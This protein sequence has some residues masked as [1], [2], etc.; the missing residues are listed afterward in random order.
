[1]S[2]KDS[3]PARHTIL[4]VDDHSL[5]S[6]GLCLLLNAEPDLKVIG[7]AADL[8]AALR[9]TERLQPEIILLDI[10]LPQGNS[11]DFLPRFRQGAPT[12]KILMLTMHEDSG[13][14]QKALDQGAVGY[15]LKRALDQDLLYAIRSV[16]RGE[17]YVQPAML[18]HLMASGT[19]P[20]TEP[21][22]P[23]PADDPEKL[24][25]SSLSEREREVITGVALG[26]TSKELGEKYFISEKTIATYRSR[27]MTK[28][29]LT[30]K[31]E[32]VELVL[33]LGIPQQP[34]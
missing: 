8:E 11:L 7:R 4:I 17:I 23:A 21:A 15:V 22:P 32:L 33:R 26:F 9:E 5:L 13:Y 3:Q 1:M 20:G 6:S 16:L 10:S 2:Q 14:L 31:S 28:L 30:S 24:L 12:A 34:G 27:A 19:R 25:W 18:K 29:G